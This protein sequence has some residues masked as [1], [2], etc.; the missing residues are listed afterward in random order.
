MTIVYAHQRRS[1]ARNIVMN[2]GAGN[3]ITPGSGDKMRVTI[4]RLGETA[5]FTVTSGTNTENGSY[6]NLAATS[7]LY[8][9]GGDLTFDLGTYSMIVDFF[10]ASEGADGEWKNV[11]LQVFSLEQRD[12]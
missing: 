4:Q 8:I 7:K 10:G 3:A 6:I 11:D 5:K 9:D 12:S 1:L 2:D